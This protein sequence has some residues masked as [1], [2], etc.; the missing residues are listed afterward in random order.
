MV[1]NYRACTTKSPERRK[2]EKRRRR[3]MAL[4]LSAK[5]LS[6]KEEGEKGLSYRQRICLKEISNITFV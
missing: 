5:L 2:E 1:L 4:P 6:A 3:E